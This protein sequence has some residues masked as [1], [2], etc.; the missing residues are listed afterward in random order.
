MNTDELIRSLAADVARPVVPIGRRL[1]KAL[2]LGTLL[3]AALFL[4][5]L[6][7]RPDIARAALTLPFVFKIVVA[8]LL[9]GTAATLLSSMARPLPKSGKLVFLVIAPLLLAAG[10]AFELSTVPSE[11][12]HAR[13][14]GHNAVHCLSLIPLLSIAPAACM[15]FALRRGAPAR[16]A[17][18]GAVAGLA[19]S[20]FGAAL[21][22]LT[23][24]DDSPLFVA[25]WYSIA[26]VIVTAASAWIGS[27]TLRW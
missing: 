25:A 26:I 6:H 22:A 11:A 18:A 19:A 3:S 2:L 16:P 21:Y 12:W 20:G 23:C 13:L 7:P 4:A 1:F 5:M 15:L 24:P 14:I 9:A 27:R 10:V 17:L 8:L